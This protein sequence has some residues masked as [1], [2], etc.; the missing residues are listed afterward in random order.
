MEANT[1]LVPLGEVA[2]FLL[3]VDGRMGVNFGTSDH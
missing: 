1:H 2:V 3:P